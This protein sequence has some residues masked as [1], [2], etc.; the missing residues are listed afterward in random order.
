MNWIFTIIFLIV[1]LLHYSLLGEGLLSFFSYESNFN[2]RIIAGF[3]FTFFLTFLI[4]FPCQVF[5]VSW[6]LYFILQVIELLLVDLL[7]FLYLRKKIKNH[8]SNIYKKDIVKSVLKIVKENW[9]CILFVFLFTCFSMA[10]QLPVYG[11]NYDDFY[12]I[13]KITNLIGA[14]HLLSEN[15]Y[16]GAVEITNGFDIIRTINTYELSYGFLSTIF[17]IDVTFFCR[18]TMVIHNYFIFVLV[19]KELASILVPR[20]Y[21]QFVL[22]PFFMFLIPQGYLHNISIMG[23]LCPIRSYDLW[24]F[25]T[26]VFYGGSVVRMLS[27]P[28]LFIFAFPMLQKLNI[29]K[30][31]WLAILSF[32]FISFSTIFIQNF[33]VFAWAIFLVYSL[34]QIYDGWKDKNRI[35][36]IGNLILCL[37]MI[38]FIGSS[39]G[40][41]HLSL[42]DTEGFHY[43][44][45]VFADFD[46]VWVQN[47]LILKIFPFIFLVGILFSKGIL[48]KSVYLFIAFI[49]ILLKSSFFYEFLTVTSFNQ[50]FVVYRT[51]SSIQYICLLLSAISIILVYLKIS[52]KILFPS[53]ISMICIIAVIVFFRTHSQVFVQYSYNGSGVSKA[54]WN[55]KRIFD[56]NNKMTPEIFYEVGEYFNSLPYGNYRFFAPSVFQFDQVDTLELGFMM[57]SNRIQIHERGGFEGITK[58]E[59]E[60]ISNYCLSDEG[61]YVA[62]N[63][64]LKKYETE[65]LLIGDE[66]HKEEMISHG[67]QEILKIDNISGPYYL[68]KL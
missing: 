50:Y 24:Q 53:V 3:F 15:Y 49:Y 29:K 62:V 33:I 12:Y 19:Y 22:V 17:H 26:A 41:D 46:N 40:W 51:I 25:Q 28:V 61:E 44:V 65:Y 5:H 6:D 54:G 35:K 9:I 52:K 7:F 16:S 45:A 36:I 23:I 20:K 8:L 63:D 34:V 31:I 14:D 57:S 39:K 60:I 37:F 43:S 58:E 64:L 55:F 56:F 59:S 2:K 47:D 4:G 66:M 1:I 27:I 30:I 38:G 10:N 68:L 67:A 18:G 48:K 32:S 42:I 21:L 11:M 13:G